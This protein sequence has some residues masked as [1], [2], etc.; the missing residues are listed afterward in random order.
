M[1]INRLFIMIALMVSILS[2]AAFALKIEPASFD[3]VTRLNSTNSFTFKLINDG[4]STLSNVQI[5]QSG[6]TGL[7]FIFTPNTINSMVPGAEQQIK[8]DILTPSNAKVQ[9]YAGTINAEAATAS[10]RNPITVEVRSMLAIEKLDAKFGDSEASN[11]R[12]GESITVD[13]E[14]GEPLEFTIRVR[15]EFPSGTD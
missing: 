2:S 15:N 1:K 12:D 11:L 5:S 10:A 8:A 13:A 6:I 3:Y 9:Q 4:A 7:Q 14:P